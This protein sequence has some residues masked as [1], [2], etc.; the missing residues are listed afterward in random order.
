MLLPALMLM[1]LFAVQFAIWAHAGSVVQAAAA[2]GDQVARSL[3]ST[4]ADGVRSAQS[5]IAEVGS[6]VVV[7]PSV[8][9]KVM[10]GGIVEMSVRASA[11]AILPGLHFGVSAVRLGPIQEFRSSQ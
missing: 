10:P 1:V 3:G 9:A 11:E 7:S 2:Q 6:G 5:F 8:T 4:P